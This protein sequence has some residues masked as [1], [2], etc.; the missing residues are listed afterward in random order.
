MSAGNQNSR[1]TKP[2]ES[3]QVKELA[4]RS[5]RA[6]TEAG[7]PA[8]PKVPLAASSGRMPRNADADL[9]PTSKLHKDELLGLLDLAAG[10]VAAPAESRPAHARLVPAGS[11][12][13]P[14]ATTA[15]DDD[16]DRQTQ[17]LQAK[18]FRALVENGQPATPALLETVDWYGDADAAA[19]DKSR[20]PR[21]PE[22]VLD[23]LGHEPSRKV[24]VDPEPELAGAAP[25][26][27][28]APATKPRA[29]LE[30]SPVSGHAEARREDAL[31]AT[32]PFGAALLPQ[33][34]S[35]STRLFIGLL[36]VAIIAFAC[37]IGFTM[38]T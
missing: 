21:A 28:P 38:T 5:V 16:D 9:R 4:S 26:A 25:A 27:A 30:V 2:F 14:P 8:P 31:L 32:R 13:E 29:S 34:P 35:S 23:E 18:H 10:Q 24:I 17:R 15:Q 22:A 20:P 11:T 19:A 7:E 33:A 36:V 3:Q 6:P 1:I 37:Y 12:S